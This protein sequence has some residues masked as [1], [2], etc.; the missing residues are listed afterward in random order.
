MSCL[1]NVTDTRADSP[2]TN[3]VLNT[4]YMKLELVKV[5]TLRKRPE[6]YENNLKSNILDVVELSRKRFRCRC[7]TL[8]FEVEDRNNE[9]TN[10]TTKKFVYYGSQVRWLEF[11]GETVV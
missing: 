2:E 10:S 11:T 3:Q 1:T 7:Q 9:E 8:K 4:I 5:K 6:K